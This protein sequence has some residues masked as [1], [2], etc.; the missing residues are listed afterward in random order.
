[1]PGLT[2]QNVAT[3]TRA[4]NAKNFVRSL[5]FRLLWNKKGLFLLEPLSNVL[6]QL[7]PLPA[8]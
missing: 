6:R 5:Y 4:A 7:D 8:E 1:M 2:E 3:W